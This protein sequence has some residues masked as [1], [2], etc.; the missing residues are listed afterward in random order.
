MTDF[1]KRLMLDILT[2]E[3]EKMIG[4]VVNE[5]TKGRLC[6]S[7]SDRILVNFPGL[8]FTVGAEYGK[9]GSGTAFVLDAFG[10]RL[11]QVTISRREA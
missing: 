10:L 2:D 7:I 8:V 5:E 9:G 6:K 11:A 1:N 3:L 4:E